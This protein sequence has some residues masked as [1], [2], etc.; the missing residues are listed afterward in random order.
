M[1]I[2]YPVSTPTSIGIAN[3]ELTAT[4]AVAVSRSPFTFSQQVHTYP[5]QMWSATVSIPPVRKDLAEPW[6][7]FL[8]SLRGQTGTF[9]LGDP[10]NT[11]PRGTAL[12]FRKNLLSFTEQFDQWFRTSFASVS[13]NTHT[14]PDGFVTADTLEKTEGTFVYFI[15][16]GNTVSGETYTASIYLKQ[17]T[18]ATT[19]LRAYKNV[20]EGSNLV[21][22]A[23]TVDWSNPS[24]TGVSVGDGWYRF[25]MTVTAID[26][27]VNLL[28]YPAGT[29]VDTGTVIAWGAQLEQGSAATDYQPIASSYGPFVKGVGQTGGTLLVDGASPSETGY[30]LAGDYIQ[31]G[32]G[33]SSTLHKVLVDVDTNEAGDATLEIWPGIRNAPADN[34]VVSVAD[35]KG[36]F[37]LSSNNQSWSINDNSA[38][39]IQFEC[40][41]VV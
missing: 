7:A 12:S 31:L 35:C 18:A 17:G 34:A 9:L 1:A 10:N 5:G 15:R 40:M 26:E 8:L 13:A 16:K 21:G 23:L 41:E 3:V 24:A 36:V 28:V 25:S 14:A 19:V 33:S 4:N 20:V 37:R 32:S 27:G 22:G 29:G 38:Y 2:T 30:L 6:V 11:T 39:G